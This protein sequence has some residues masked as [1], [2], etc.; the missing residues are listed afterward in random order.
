M[1]LSAPRGGTL[2]SKPKMHSAHKILDGIPMEEAECLEPLLTS[3]PDAPLD[4]KPMAGNMI[5]NSSDL[6]VPQKDQTGRHME[7]VTSPAPS[8]RLVTQLHLDSQP[9]SYQSQ[10]DWSRYPMSDDIPHIQA[11]TPGNQTVPDVV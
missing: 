9:S 11:E 6:A 10:P 1:I 4:N 2:V 8:R 3:V 5:R 7:G